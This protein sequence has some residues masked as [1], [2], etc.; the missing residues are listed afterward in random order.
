MKIGLVTTEE[1]HTDDVIRFTF[2]N[3]DTISGRVTS[4]PRGGMIRVSTQHS[5]DTFFST[6]TVTGVEKLEERVPV[7]P[8]E[9]DKALGEL[10]G[11]LAYN[12]FGSQEV[13]R[14]V[15]RTAKGTWIWEGKTTSW[16]RIHDDMDKDFWFVQL[17]EQTDVSGNVFSDEEV[18]IAL[19]WFEAIDFDIPG[20]RDDEG[21]PIMTE[22]EKA[23]LEKLKGI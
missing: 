8:F 14:P 20:G 18:H 7:A 10:W 2:A 23:F 1:I 5:G 11:Y 12:G 19:S 16:D 9:P 17:V 22:P 6:D 15:H 4:P 3:G 13:R 21:N